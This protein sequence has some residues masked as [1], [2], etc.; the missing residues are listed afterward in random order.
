[1]ARDWARFAP[2]EDPDPK[3]IDLQEKHSDLKWDYTA[4]KHKL[5]D[6]LDDETQREVLEERL[7]YLRMMV[8]DLEME[9][10]AF[11]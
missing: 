2:P 10:E 6:E 1:M 9:M 3:Y 5:E 4:L 11:D 7:L 8:Q